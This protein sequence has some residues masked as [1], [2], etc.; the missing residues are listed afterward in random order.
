MWNE[1]TLV[2]SLFRT[3]DYFIFLVFKIT[4]KSSAIPL[5]DFQNTKLKSYRNLGGFWFAFLLLLLFLVLVWGFFAFQC[6]QLKCL[7]INTNCKQNSFSSALW[8]YLE[9]SQYTD[10][11]ACSCTIVPN[12]KVCIAFRLLGALSKLATQGKS[13]AWIHLLPDIKYSHLKIDIA[14]SNPGAV[15]Y[16]P[17]YIQVC[18]QKVWNQ[19]TCH[20]FVP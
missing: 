20:S 14:R 19:C 16:N 7:I 5:G 4:A 9:L 2:L 18:M 11:K 6:T 15:C 10:R 3:E 13:R 1:I 12:N 8:N 17:H